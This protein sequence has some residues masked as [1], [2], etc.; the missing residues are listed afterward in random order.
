MNHLV[1]A[2]FTAKTLKIS[3]ILFYIPDLHFNKKN[4]VFLKKKALNEE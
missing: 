2:L 1:G 3:I 4:S